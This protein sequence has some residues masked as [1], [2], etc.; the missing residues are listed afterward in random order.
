MVDEC[1][2][3]ALLFAQGDTQNQS[4]AATSMQRNQP[5]AEGGIQLTPSKKDLDAILQDMLDAED[6]PIE[7]DESSNACSDMSS[8]LPFGNVI[9]SDCEESITTGLDLSRTNSENILSAEGQ[10]Y[11]PDEVKTFMGRTI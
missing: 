6:Q 4:A 7:N 11:C 3:S 9:P 2:E 8:L 1:P 10:P 5:I